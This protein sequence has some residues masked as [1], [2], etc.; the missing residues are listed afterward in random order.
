MVSFSKTKSQED[1]ILGVRFEVIFTAIWTCPHAQSQIPCLISV[2]RRK[3]QSK[4]HKYLPLGVCFER[5]LSKYVPKHIPQMSLLRV[6][7]STQHSE[8]WSFLHGFPWFSTCF[9]AFP[10]RYRH[11]CCYVSECVRTSDRVSD[12][13]PLVLIPQ[14][15]PSQSIVLTAWK[16]LRLDWH[17]GQPLDLILPAGAITAH[18]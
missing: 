5:N 7:C 18:V 12:H 9:L 1:K 3:Y 14:C 13:F 8:T 6:M 17:W 15:I 16:Y 2:P 11:V 4:F 10:A